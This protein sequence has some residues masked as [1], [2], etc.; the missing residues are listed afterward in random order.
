MVISS[1]RLVPMPIE[2]I[3]IAG[4]GVAGWVTGATLARA[5]RCAIVVIDHEGED[6]SLGYPSLAEPALPSIAEFHARAGFDEDALLRASKATFTLGRAL[7]GWSP[8]AIL[9]FHPYG[10]IGVGIGATA[11][12]QLVAALR[13]KGAQINLANYALAALCAQASRFTRATEDMRSVLST[14]NYGVHVDTSLYAEAMK[15]D[16]L[17]HGAQV[18][19][20]K[21]GKVEVARGLIKSV[22]TQAGERIAGD[23]FVDCTG[24]EAKLI[25]GAL[26]IGLESWSEWLPCQHL[27]NKITP[28]STPPMPYTH[29][30]AHGEGWRRYVPL[31]GYEV[32]TVCSA[33]ARAEGRFRPGRRAALWAGNCIAIGGSAAV[34]DPLAST[35]LHFVHS[36]AARLIRFFPHAPDAPV[37]AAEYNRQG[38]EELDRARDYAILHYK[39][40]SRAAEPFWDACRAMSVPDRLSHKIA[41]FE[42]C[43]RVALHDNEV[44]EE[45]DW[46]ALFDLLGCRARRFDALANAVPQQTIEQHFA[47]LREVMLQAVAGLPT[48]SDYI[49]GHI[50]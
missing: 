18:S 10:E 4:G 41:L 48:H 9:G 35:T 17:A 15:R 47:R 21:I 44:F 3:V 39:S 33:D 11:F 12:H 16:A 19:L 26:G 40:N 13:S 30:E 5:T 36:A 50:A 42:S 24:A 46:V 29:T 49:R 22:S 38:I 28:T 20:G 32:E 43:G 6:V 23:L 45:S 7:V 34:L 1:A 14:M 37:E 25:F 2:R 27:V 31:Q 8:G